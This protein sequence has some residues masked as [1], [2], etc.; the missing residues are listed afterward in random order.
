MLHQTT[1][2]STFFEAFVCFSRFAGVSATG[3][4]KAIQVVLLVK[5][6]ERLQMNTHLIDG[7]GQ[8]V[9]TLAQL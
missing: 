9:M 1:G 7:G 3:I 5:L 4:L 8:M 6:E 2:I